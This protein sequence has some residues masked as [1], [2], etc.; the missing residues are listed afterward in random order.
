MLPMTMGT[1]GISSISV[2]QTQPQSI[3]TLFFLMP[4]PNTPSITSSR[5]TTQLPF[6][7]TATEI[8]TVS[9]SP[10]S[11]I[12]LS[13]TISQSGLQQSSPSLELEL[14]TSTVHVLIT[15]SQAG[16]ATSSSQAATTGLQGLVTLSEH[17]TATFSPTNTATT[18]KAVCVHTLLGVFSTL[19]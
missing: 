4:T 19:G 6:Q 11:A 7:T 1:G 5:S 2:T 15:S 18:G 12:S 8:S 3:P 14:P 16:Q 13:S 9:S 17:P 10:P